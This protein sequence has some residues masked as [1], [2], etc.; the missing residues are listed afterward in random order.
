[1]AGGSAIG[2]L[3]VY[4]KSL[5][6]NK[7]KSHLERKVL[8]PKRARPN[9]RFVKGPGGPGNHYFSKSKEDGSRRGCGA[10]CEQICS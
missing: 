9:A 8:E 2:Y 6:T 1:M 5:K 4:Q 3:N 10:V 7:Q